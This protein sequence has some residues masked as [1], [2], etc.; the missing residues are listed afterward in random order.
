[1]SQTLLE[2]EEVSNLIAGRGLGSSI[3]WLGVAIADMFDGSNFEISL[4]PDED[5]EDTIL[6]IAVH[7]DYKSADFRTRMHLLC[8]AMLKEGHKYLYAVASIF[9][10]RPIDAKQLNDKPKQHPPNAK[11]LS[12]WW[13]NGDDTG[14]SFS[15]YAAMVIV[16]QNQEIIERLDRMSG[17]DA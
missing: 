14:E 11:W 3:D 17:R 4:L 15:D 12:T 7:S 1:M 6:S 5:R 9:Q 10:R 16:K 13:Y 2:K 8:D